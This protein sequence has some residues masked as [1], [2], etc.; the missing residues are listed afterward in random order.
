[1]TRPITAQ[2]GILLVVGLGLAT[3][4]YGIPTLPTEIPV[5]SAAPWHPTNTPMS[6][7]STLHPTNTIVPS[8]AVIT[9]SELRTA[10]P[11]WAVF[12]KMPITPYTVEALYQ[13]FEHGF[14]IWRSDENCAYALVSTEDRGANSADAII[15]AEMPSTDP[16]GYGYCLSVAPL[17]GRDVISTPPTGLMLPA[18]VLRV[19][20][21]YYE[22]IRMQL[23]YATQP[24][25]RYT[26]TIP[27]V[28]DS[29][30]IG[31]PYT[32][33]QMTLP[34]GHILACGSRGATAG[35]CDY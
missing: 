27:A 3:C 7:T 17:T 33:P 28:N 18:G 14:M 19:V 30:G 34:N 29:H 15:P 12:P 11:T 2:L 5:P 23:G 16:P 4:V 21:A 10:T 26:A 8:T 35:T 13:P 1:M 6:S 31:G 24:E 9:L 32:I 25:T 22:E 20:W